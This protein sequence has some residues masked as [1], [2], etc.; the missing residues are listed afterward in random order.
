MAVAL[1]LLAKPKSLGHPLIPGLQKF[2]PFAKVAAKLAPRMQALVMMLDEWQIFWRLFGSLDAW[3]ALKALLKEVYQRV[4]FEERI[5]WALEMGQTFSMACYY[6][7]EGIGWLGY[8]KALSSSSDHQAKMYRWSSWGWC[9]GM[10]F[11]NARGMVDWHRKE[12]AGEA[13]SEWKSNL[14]KVFIRNTA[15][16]LVAANL[17]VEGGFLPDLL[18]AGLG[19]YASVSEITDLWKDT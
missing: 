14:R 18:S 10:L 17:G 6:V 19:T 16:A 3:F 1:Y 11:D 9:G 15:W 12:R 4:T 13:D 2:G 8:W 5:D 7:F